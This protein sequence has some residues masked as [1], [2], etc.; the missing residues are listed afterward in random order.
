MKKTPLPPKAV[1]CF[2]EI[3][4]DCLPRGMFLGGAPLNVACHLRMLGTPAL[5]V[6]CVGR[7]ML[8][9]EARQRVRDLGL[10]DRY[11]GTS[12]K[13][14]TG[15]VRVWLDEGGN[16]R[17]TIA[18]S[19]AWDRIRVSSALLDEASN[20]AAVVFGSLAQRSRYNRGQ[21]KKLLSRQPLLKVFDVNL[22]PPFDD[23]P[24]ILRL[25][26]T[27][28]LVKLN[29]E[30]LHRLAGDNGRNLPLERAARTLHKMIP[31][32]CLCVT[33]GPA[34]AALLWKDSW[35]RVRGRKV[36]VRDTV[37]AGDA[38][39]ASLLHHLL[40]EPDHPE[41]ALRQA[42]R[43]GEFVATQD[44]AIPSYDATAFRA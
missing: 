35:I 33:L 9:D 2:G 14:A 31:Q 13:L 32:A 17:Y 29:A 44:G 16:A 37:G 12:R 38:F 6:S 39:L 20:C 40:A 3:L 36:L 4:W 43:L 27:A 10:E 26:E 11:I 34:G 7:D 19:V 28:D 25:A 22:R 23:V 8:G 24:S 18:E 30:E 15:T 21:L 1:I 5:P 41:T 42:C